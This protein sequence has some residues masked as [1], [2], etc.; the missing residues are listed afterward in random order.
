LFLYLERLN[1]NL[2][3]LK[4]RFSIAALMT[5][6]CL[7]SKAQEMK[8]IEQ[9]IPGTSLKIK[10]VP[11]PAGTFVMGSGPG[12]KTKEEDEL[13]S[14][15]VSVSAFWMA[16]HEMTFEQWDAFFKN[17]DVP[18]TKAVPVD[19]IS[20][21]TAQYIDL[22]WGMGRDPK[23]PT[24]SMSQTA[25]I[26]YCKWLYNKTGIFYRLP[27][28][29]EWEYACRAGSTTS[30]PTGVSSKNLVEF[31]YFKANS[32]EKF[33][34]VKQLKPNAWGLYDMLGNLS[35]WTLDQY[36]PA[37]YQKLA[38]TAKDPLTPPAAKYPRVARGGSYQDEADVLRCTNR[39]PSKPEWNQRDPQIPKSRWWLTDG[40]FM[41]F[42][43]VK[44]A[45]QPSK[46]QIEQFFS[47][48][49]R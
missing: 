15:K 7:A 31:G 35:E 4:F 33:Q 47:S 39:I 25:G 30:L 24:N 26:M 14:K 13:P 1:Y 9:Q 17:M 21:P 18:Q 19:G 48:Y 23:H 27:T 6:C 32:G 40:M 44:P 10:L 8:V 5:V 28:E 37:S 36:D 38:A 29:A 2:L 22:T 43:I 16:E 12:E 11:I 20:R 41:G 3:S 46:E 42:R 49:L 45:Q 34:K